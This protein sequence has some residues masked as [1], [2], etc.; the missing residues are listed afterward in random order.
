[1]A[2]TASV[3]VSELSTTLS[4]RAA[5]GNLHNRD[6]NRPHTAFRSFA[7]VRPPN[8]ENQPEDD[9]FQQCL[10]PVNRRPKRRP[11]KARVERDQPTKSSRQQGSHR[12]PE[13]MDIR[14]VIEEMQRETNKLRVSGL[15][16]CHGDT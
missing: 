15:N 6:P 16:D 12:L 1:M 11:N 4:A 7:R 9:A 2:V 5:A 14:N 10:R 8:V 13:M 3:A